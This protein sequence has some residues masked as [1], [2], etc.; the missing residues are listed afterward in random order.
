MTDAHALSLIEVILTGQ[1]RRSE[2]IG[3][4]LCHRFSC[5]ASSTRYMAPFC[6]S[7]CLVLFS[8]YLTPVPPE[9]PQLLVAETGENRSA[10][11]GFSEIHLLVIPFRVGCATAL[12]CKCQE[13]KRKARF[14]QQQE[15]GFY[16]WRRQK[17]TG[18]G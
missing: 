10:T 11:R 8:E 12:P 2:L 13:P 16:A 7:S 14:L 17:F 4:L 18:A 9:I 15:A 1:K 5:Q 3:R 6:P